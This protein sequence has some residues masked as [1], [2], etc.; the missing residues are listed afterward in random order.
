MSR[1][2]LPVTMNLKNEW[3]LEP[4]HI[5]VWGMVSLT[6]MICKS[7]TV[8]FAGLLR[9]NQHGSSIRGN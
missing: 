2:I 9:S 6:Y 7:H 4:F 1:Q 5:K 3:T 8:N